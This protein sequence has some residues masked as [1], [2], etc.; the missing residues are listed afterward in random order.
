MIYDD[1]DKCMDNDR[2]SIHVE[3]IPSNNPYSDTKLFGLKKLDMCVFT[4]SLLT[5]VPKEDRVAGRGIHTP[6]VIDISDAEASLPVICG[7][8][9]CRYEDISNRV[10]DLS[11]QVILQFALAPNL[12]VVVTL[13]NSVLHV[14]PRCSNID[15]GEVIRSKHTLY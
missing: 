9:K 14:D 13:A 4:A 6:G 10:R 12:V 7:K 11:N 3:L 15:S 8:M 1:G 5:Y 2:Y